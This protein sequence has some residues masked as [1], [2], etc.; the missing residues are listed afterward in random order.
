M[1]TYNLDISV[2]IADIPILKNGGYRLCIAKRVNGKYDVVWSGG[3][4]IASN[5]FAWDA[6]FQVFGALKFQGGFQVKAG[7]NPEELKFG[8][9]VVLDSNGVMQ[10]ATGP[11]DKSGVF[12]VQN[13]Y[14]AMCIGVNAKLGGAW[15]PIYLSQTPFASGVVSL[16]P[17][18]KV[19]VW[20]DALSSTGTMLVDAVTN[21]IEL[22]F[23]G[24]TSQ[25]V[26]YAS[27]P[28]KPG[29]GGWIVG[30]SAVLSS[31]YH[32]DTD[33]FSL[34]T[35][36]APLLGKLST[37]INSQNSLPLS[38]LAVSASLEFYDEVS[39]EEFVRYAFGKRPE[40]VRNW[41]FV[42]TSTVVELK[43]QTEKDQEDELAVKF[44]QDAYLGVLYSFPGPEYMKLTFQIL[45]RHS[46]PTSAETNVAPAAPNVVDP[47]SSGELRIIYSS[48]SQAAD[49]AKG[50]T[51]LAGNGLAY[52]ADVHSDDKQWV[53]VLLS[54][55]FP[56]GNV[57]QDRHAIVDP[58]AT[59]L[60]GGGQY[61]KQ[62]P[63]FPN[64]PDFVMY[65][66]QWGKD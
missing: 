30:G 56:S 34:E 41:D 2:N 31:T 17:I 10:P 48:A 57:D 61:F 45:N 15:S 54:L 39:A 59:A 6:E 9:S 60:F 19:L 25:S 12:K 3:A 37:L 29:N 13:N 43:L 49:A 7:T 53:R 35:P 33:T 52:V 20:F 36:S 11:T 42:Q 62:P 4:F 23:T 24:K 50:I 1:S 8:Q 28:N 40:G 47:R 64:T 55:T 44:L 5:S 16:T 21:S 26:T 18:E 66:V 38:K 51:A 14:G 27:D 63:L 58:L 32:V 46:L 65:A 22:D